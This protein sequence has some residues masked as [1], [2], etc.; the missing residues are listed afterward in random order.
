MSDV[1]VKNPESPVE[2][3]A[4]SESNPVSSP[5]NA[6]TVDNSETETE[7]II[8]VELP[9]S[10]NGIL[11]KLPPELHIRL[12][13]T[14]LKYSDSNND[15]DRLA[16]FRFA[17]VNKYFQALSQTGTCLLALARSPLLAP[18]RLVYFT[19]YLDIVVSNLETSCPPIEGFH[20]GIKE[21]TSMPTSH[22]EEALDVIEEYKALK[23]FHKRIYYHR[24]RQDPRYVDDREF[25]HFLTLWKSLGSVFPWNN[26]VNCLALAL[27]IDRL[28]QI[29]W[30]G[31]QLALL[32]K[33]AESMGVE[34]FQVP[35]MPGMPAMPAM[36]GV[37][38]MS[39]WLCGVL[40]YLQI[41]ARRVTGRG[42]KLQLD[43][44]FMKRCFYGRSWDDIYEFCWMEDGKRREWLEE[45]GL[46]EVLD[47]TW[48]W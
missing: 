17:S 3:E 12:L 48:V 37:G 7:S 5:D 29:P 10:S 31:E 22:R 15:D 32:K 34:K 25:A 35:E 13:T 26:D 4:N 19:G 47:G 43:W 28:A 8:D 38:E 16:F 11:S 20:R 27:T 45:V 42:E 33:T 46:K 44:R 41:E 21:M 40:E 2:A 1:V 6:E 24:W 36:G 9:K 18:A 39:I 30:A 23:H 14:T